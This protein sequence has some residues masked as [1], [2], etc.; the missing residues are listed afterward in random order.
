VTRIREGRS[1]AQT[2][3]V[4]RAAAGGLQC[5]VPLKPTLLLVGLVT[6][7]P[8]SGQDFWDFDDQRVVS[9]SGRR[10]VV[11]CNAGMDGVTFEFCE[12]AAR[13]TRIALHFARNPDRAAAPALETALQRVT[14]GNERKWVQEA[15]DACRR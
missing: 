13:A 2:P 10:Y 12:C 1:P 11:L 9:S 6:L 3:V 14:D 15:I 8:L 5:V 7:A 4:K